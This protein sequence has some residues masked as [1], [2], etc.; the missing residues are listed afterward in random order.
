MAV[1]VQTHMS[2]SFGLLSQTPTVSAP[3]GAC[4]ATCFITR[5]TFTRKLRW[6][7]FGYVYV[8]TSIENCASGANKKVQLRV[9]KSR[10]RGA[11][12][13]TCLMC[14][15]LGRLHWLYGETTR[16]L[17]LTHA[18]MYL[19]ITGVWMH[20][21]AA[22]PTCTATAQGSAEIAQVHN[23]AYGPNNS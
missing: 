9:K 21:N 11:G 14:M 22:V 18:W 2:S 16:P 10:A 15:V 7:H 19:S 3:P 12:P 4:Q 23:R 17:T 6:R 8:I 1:W 13:G 20:A 5:T